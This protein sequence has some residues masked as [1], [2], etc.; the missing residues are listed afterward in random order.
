MSEKDR[1]KYRV[2]ITHM[3]VAQGSI[4]NVI[5]TLKGQA[6]SKEKEKE[7]DVDAPETLNHASQPEKKEKGVDTLEDCQKSNPDASNSA[8]DSSSDS[9]SSTSRPK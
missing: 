1:K 7:K 9:S 2:V 6:T 8:S 5:E 3:S 4:E